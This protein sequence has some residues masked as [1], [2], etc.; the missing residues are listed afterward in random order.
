[1]GVTVY[2]NVEIWEKK[3]ATILTKQTDANRISN[4]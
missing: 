4:S 3:D 2:Y 1:M